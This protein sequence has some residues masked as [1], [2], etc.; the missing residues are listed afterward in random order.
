M[1]AEKG[2]EKQ[3]YPLSPLVLL[4]QGEAGLGQA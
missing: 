3:I 4:G 2:Q 1:K